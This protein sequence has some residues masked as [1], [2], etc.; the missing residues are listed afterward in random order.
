[1]TPEEKAAL[2]SRLDAIIDTFEH[3][4]DPARLEIAK[5]DLAEIWADLLESVPI[6]GR[7]LESRMGSAK[8][9]LRAE[10]TEHIRENLLPMLKRYRDFLAGGTPGR[11][12]ATANR[13]TRPGCSGGT[14]AVLLALVFLLLNRLA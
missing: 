14:T 8:G 9:E 1:M 2:L 11:A 6:I 5:A 4:Q 3:S 13:P 7:M 10:S 12:S